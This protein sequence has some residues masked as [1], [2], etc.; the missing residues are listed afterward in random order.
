MNKYTFHNK[1][2]SIIRHNLSPD[3]LIEVIRL[4]LPKDCESADLSFNDIFDENTI[5][6]WHFV[7]KIMNSED[8]EEVEDYTRI[9]SI[10]KRAGKWYQAKVAMGEIKLQKYTPVTGSLEDEY[11]KLMKSDHPGWWLLA[12]K[13]SSVIIE[14]LEC[15]F[16]NSQRVSDLSPSM[17]DRINYPYIMRICGEWLMLNHPEK[18]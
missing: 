15:D 12:H 5:K 8:F 11:F 3:M 4:D 1:E 13:E 9:R 16:N 14:F 18:L 10:L 6:G 17:P 2:K 7:F